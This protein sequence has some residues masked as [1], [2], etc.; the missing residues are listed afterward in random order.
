MDMTSHVTKS[1][2]LIKVLDDID[3][4][5]LGQGNSNGK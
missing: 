2:Y 4:F 5:M 1:E 3:K